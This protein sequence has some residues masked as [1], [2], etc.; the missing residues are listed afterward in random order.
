[1]A[2]KYKDN[3]G[4]SSSLDDYGLILV[5]VPTEGGDFGGGFGFNA[6]MLKHDLLVQR[7]YVYGYPAGAQQLQGDISKVEDVEDRVIC[8][9]VATSPG[10]SGAPVWIKASNGNDVLV[11]IQ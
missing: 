2:Q 3:P 8:H 7:V 9:N 11:G 5:D 10:V 6:H 4:N 1:V